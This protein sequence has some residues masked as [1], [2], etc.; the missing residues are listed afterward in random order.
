M[1]AGLIDF[2]CASLI[3]WSFATKLTLKILHLLFSG[4]FSLRSLERDLLGGRS[5]KRDIP[6]LHHRS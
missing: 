6:E 1:S 5:A 3:S 4:I 2:D